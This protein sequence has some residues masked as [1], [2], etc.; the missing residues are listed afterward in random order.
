MAAIHGKATTVLYNG[1]DI[2]T[3]LNDIS[4]SANVDTVET[5]TFGDTAKKYIAGL[6]DGSA[7]FGGFWSTVA[8]EIDD[9]LATTF[10]AGET[11]NVLTIA[12]A[13]TTLGNRGQMLAG[14]HTTYEV[15]GSIGDAVGITGEMQASGGVDAG[16]FVHALGADTATGN[17][18]SVDNSAASTNGYSM[19]QHITAV[20]GT[21]PSMTSK[22]QHS[23]DDS[24]WVDLATFTA[25][26][27]I[28][29]QQVTGTGTVNRYVRE[30]H[31]ISGTNPSFTH[32]VIFGRR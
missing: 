27:A 10:A 13:G 15:A 9:I 21:T 5:S 6:K 18:T 3:Y 32:A 11:T 25:A 28:R 16:R 19:N 17:S 24:V 26:T 22:V 23:T 7:S 2:S 20:S 29:G 4:V 14:I 31:T 1:Y 30:V 12:P 8:G